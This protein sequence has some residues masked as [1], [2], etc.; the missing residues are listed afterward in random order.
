L[1]DGNQSDPQVKKSAGAP[2]RLQERQ[3]PR[4]KG[5]RHPHYLG[6]Q[7]IGGEGQLEKGG[8]NKKRTEGKRPEYFLQ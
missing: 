5:T 3:M 1:L 6:N 7:T 4:E 2:T 8:K